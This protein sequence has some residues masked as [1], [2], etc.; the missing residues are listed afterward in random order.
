MALLLNKNA[1]NSSLP[2]FRSLL[3]LPLPV[4]PGRPER[5]SPDSRGA[6]SEYDNPGIPGSLA[7]RAP[8]ND[9]HQ[10]PNHA[11]GRVPVTNPTYSF[12]LAA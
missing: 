6:A 9:E 1:A 2:T 5:P 7:L 8:R 4:I 11:T 10:A 12:L 3:T